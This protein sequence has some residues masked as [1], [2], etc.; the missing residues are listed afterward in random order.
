MIKNGILLAGG[1]G[2]RLRPFSNIYSKQLIYLAGKC[3]I[4]FPIQ[5]LID[6]GIENLTIVLGSSFAGQIVDYCGDGRKYGLNIN[7]TYQE[8]PAGISQAIKLCEKYVFNDDKF[9]VILG[10]NIFF[11]KITYNEKSGA[12]IFL[13]R[14]STYELNR[15]GV[16]SIIN[17]KIINIEEKPKILDGNYDNYAIS[18][19]YQFDNNFFRY[20]DK[21]KKSDRG[22][23]EVTDIIK[24]YHND[25]NLNYQIINGEWD[26]AGT[27]ESLN[28]IN[29]KLIGKN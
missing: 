17:N 25:G 29:Y 2:S 20:F 22:E 8:Q 19:L 23:F 12:N 28:R 10:D 7:Y 16:A 11:D 18:G 5:T 1:I 26:D 13:A 9:F 15:F 27:I 14:H 6:L 21:T 24:Y 4:D 3:V